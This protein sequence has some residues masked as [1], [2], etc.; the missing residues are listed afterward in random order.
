MHL[1]HKAG[2]Q[3]YVDFTGQK[4]SFTD[5]E[6]G[7][8]TKVEVFVAI[9]GASQLTYVAASQANDFFH[10]VIYQMEVAPADKYQAFIR[11][12]DEQGKPYNFSF[13]SKKDSFS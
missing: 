4:L 12:P 13:P 10:L 9:L 11:Y 8:I 1:D 7:H 2:D 5:Q 6:S 3:L